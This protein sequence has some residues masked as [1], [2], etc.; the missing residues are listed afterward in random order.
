MGWDVGERVHAQPCLD[1]TCLVTLG[2]KRQ[3][4]Q[5]LQQLAF[6]HLTMHLA[7]SVQALVNALA[8]GKA[9]VHT[10]HGASPLPEEVLALVFDR[11]VADL[12]P[13][14]VWGPGL[15]AW[16]LA[17]ASLV[18]PGARCMLIAVWARSYWRYV[19]KCRQCPQNRTE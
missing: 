16:Q 1:I 14:G 3:G 17:S 8:G 12:E 4:V 15:V 9:P 18:G 10:K 7:S 6:L 2:L 11:L 13:G 5:K 19:R